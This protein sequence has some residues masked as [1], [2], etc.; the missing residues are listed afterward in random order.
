[1]AKVRVVYWK[2]IPAQIQARG[3]GGDT[4]SRP[5]AERFQEGIDAVA[6]F[7]GSIGTDEYLEGWGRGEWFDEPGTAEEAADRVVERYNHGFPK[8]FVA[9]LRKH[10]DDGLRDPKPGA[11]DNWIRSS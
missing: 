5:L 2:E 1:M 9:R 4:I 3:D 6:M 10:L 7:D 11:V 8:N